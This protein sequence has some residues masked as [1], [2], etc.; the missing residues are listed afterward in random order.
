MTVDLPTL[1]RVLLRVV[2]RGW[3]VERAA[4]D[5]AIPRADVTDALTQVGNTN[6]ARH[7]RQALADAS[8]GKDPRAAA[9]AQEGVLREIPVAD[10]RAHPQNVR[11]DLGDV[12]E[13]ATS[14]TARGVLQPL[15]VAKRGPGLFVVLD[16]HRRLA[17]ARAA[18]LPTVPCVVADE[19]SVTATMLA[20]AMHKSLTAI[21][22]AAAFARFTNKGVSVGQISAATG[23]S[24][25]TVRDRLALLD[26]PADA[27]Q[28]V[29]DK[30]LTTKAATGL[31]R[32]VKASGTGQATTRNPKTSHFTGSHPLAGDVRA[33]CKHRDTRVTV[34]GVGCGQCWEYLITATAVADFVEGKQ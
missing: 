7:M 30:Q 32:Q 24:T 21:E 15:L 2:D 19:K 20:A 10:L 3:S 18:G 9:T 11:D 25:R 28:L 33:L 1:E 26:L 22:Q 23:Y 34:G 6:D 29:A 4:R 31:A 8:A 5:L 14:L 27:Q 16:G 17:A 13:L 12:N